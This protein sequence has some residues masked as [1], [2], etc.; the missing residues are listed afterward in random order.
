[1]KSVMNIEFF[2]LFCIVSGLIFNWI[3]IQYLFYF[4]GIW[5]CIDECQC[6]VND[7]L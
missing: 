3:N 1:M 5:Y 2:D 4:M 7:V 6:I